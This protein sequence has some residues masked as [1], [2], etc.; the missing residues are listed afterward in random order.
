MNQRLAS[1]HDDLNKLLNELH[2]ELETG[3][4]VRSHAQL[5][6]FWA[7]LAMHIRAEHLH[8]FPAILKGLNTDKAKDVA[9]APSLAEAQSTIEQL[10]RDHDFFM[11]ELSR[12]IA[13][14]RNL[15]QAT[16]RQMIG[17]QLEQVRATVT[18]V[19]ERLSAHNSIEEDY[20]YLWPARLLSEVEQSA[21]IERVEVELRKMPPRFLSGAEIL[22]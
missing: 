11:H 17:R 7:R 10:R 13:S 20:V 22:Q 8:L 5:D 1:D 18:A 19:Q 3:D 4:V 15:L 12:A 16:D 9:Q 6:L 2:A 14:L 21:L